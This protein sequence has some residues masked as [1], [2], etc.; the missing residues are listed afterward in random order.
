MYLF[1]SWARKQE[2]ASSDM[3]VAIVSRSQLSAMTW[4]KLLDR[5]EESSLPYKVDIVHVQQTNA[6]MRRQIEQEGI[7]WIDYRND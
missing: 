4:N 3:D 5:V 6:S 2:K 1:G 7:V